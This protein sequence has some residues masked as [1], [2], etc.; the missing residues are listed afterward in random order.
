MNKAEIEKA[1]VYMIARRAEDIHATAGSLEQ[2]HQ[3][4]RDWQAQ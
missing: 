4:I 2:N 1:M 3:N